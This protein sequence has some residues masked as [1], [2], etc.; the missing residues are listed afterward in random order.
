MIKQLK[1]FALLPAAER[2]WFWLCWWQFAKWHL[3]IQYLPY[4][5]WQANLFKSNLVESKR[6]LTFSLGRAIQ[7]SEMAARHHVFPINCLRRCM[8]QQQLLGRYGYLLEFHFGVAKEHNKLKAHC[9]LTYHNKLVNDGEDV[10]S[11]YTELTLA[12]RQKQQIISSLK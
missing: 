4:H 12:E 5:K 11:T 7:I 1:Q 8:V 10:V 2:R 6:S 3:K 9:W